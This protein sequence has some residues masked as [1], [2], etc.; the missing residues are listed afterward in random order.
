VTQG[1]GI[2][3]SGGLVRAGIV[4]YNTPE[5]VDRFLGAVESVA[6]SATARVAT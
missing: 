5:E 2:E 3:E 6:R 4:H 1:L